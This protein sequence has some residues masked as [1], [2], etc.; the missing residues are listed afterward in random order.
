MATVLALYKRP[1]DAAAFDQYYFERH[2]PLAKELP[3]LRAYRVSENTVMGPDG[4]S[5]I[6]L[7]AILEFDTMSDIQSAIA[8]DAGQ[9]TIAD[10]ANFA[11]GGMDLLIFDSRPV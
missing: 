9:K 3:G 6:H 11:S 2:V 1:V 10:I 4:P 5:G 8:S 7:A